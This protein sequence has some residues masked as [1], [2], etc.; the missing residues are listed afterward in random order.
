L[1]REVDRFAN[2]ETTVRR[3]SVAQ[4]VPFEQLRDDVGSPIC[5]S[6]VVDRE[7]IGVV[8]RRYRARFL[9]EPAKMIGIGRK[10]GRQD[11]DGYVARES[12]VVGAIDL[13]HASNAERTLNFISAEAN[14]GLERHT[15]F[16]DYLRVDRPTTGLN[17]ARSTAFAMASYP[18]SFMCRLSP[19]L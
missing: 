1:D 3:Q 12:R 13:P 18:A 15:R 14:T 17:N 16:A 19:G 10:S 11:V 2:R 9:L 6:Y 5:R 8:E 4:C 7:N